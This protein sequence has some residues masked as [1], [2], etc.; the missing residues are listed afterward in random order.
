MPDEAPVTTARADGFGAGRAMDV[1]VGGG[2]IVVRRRSGR[3]QMADLSACL[4]HLPRSGEKRPVSDAL[5]CDSRLMGTR[6]SEF[7]VR[8]ARSRAGLASRRPPRGCVVAGPPQSGKTTVLQALRS[9]VDGPVITANGVGRTAGMVFSPFFPAAVVAFTAPA[10]LPLTQL[11]WSVATAIRERSAVALFIDDADQL[12]DQ[13]AA[14]VHSLV[15]HDAVPVYL[16]CT[17]DGGHPVPAALR[18]LWKDGHLPRFDLPPIDEREVHDYLLEVVGRPVTQRDVE[19]F[20]RWSGGEPG[21]LVDLVE[22]SLKAQQWQVISGTALLVERPVPPPEMLEEVE[23]LAADLSGEVLTMVEVFGAAIPAIGIRMLDWLPLAPVMELVGMDA[24]LEAERRGVIVADGDR[25]RLAVPFLADAVAR[26]TPQLRRAQIA[27][28]LAAAIKA[29]SGNPSGQVEGDQARVMTGLLTLSTTA[30]TPP[31]ERLASAR[32]ALRLGDAAAAGELASMRDGVAPT[33]EP[34]LAAVFTWASIHLNDLPG[35]Y[36]MLRTWSSDSSPAWRGLRMFLDEFTQRRELGGLGFLAR[37][38][39]ASGGLLGS[40]AER[41]RCDRLSGA[42]FGFLLAET[43]MLVGRYREA[44]ALLDLIGPAA[45]DDGLLIFHL[46]FVDERL[47]TAVTGAGRACDVVEKARRASAWRSDQVCASADFVCGLAHARAGRFD[48]ALS[49]LRNC[50]PFLVATRLQEAPARLIGR[51]DLMSTGSGPE[52]PDDEP[53]EIPVDPYALLTASEL[54]LDRAWALA[55]ADGVG[56]AVE[57]LLAFGE[58]ARESAPTLAVDQFELAAQFLPPGDS[59]AARRLVAGAEHI[60]AHV[61][62]AERV[63]A[64]VGYSAAL[65]AADGTRLKD[66]AEQY[67]RLCLLPVAA[68]VF[69]QAAAAY[70]AAGDVH[71]SL[72]SQSC[73]RRVIERIGHLASPAQRNVVR[74]SLTR[75]EEEIVALAAESL[76]N[77]QIADRLQLS[78][79]TVEGHLLRASGKFGVRDR[80]ALTALWQEQQRGSG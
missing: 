27:G 79:R 45:E 54:N 47:E 37:H 77:P 61:D 12:D 3:T 52:S 40:V 36:G 75:R 10:D 17:V 13:A 15:V 8:Q 51:V 50:A 62:S 80:R 32:S 21:V 69:A 9:D 11:R 70:R 18:S 38:D 66:A 14:I 57:R 78:V 59:D 19:A 44:R 5:P 43:A 58:G 4:Y 6:R 72:A 30:T 56:A 76:T 1:I 7:R 71:G 28:E 73:A 68:D 34:E 39:G 22:S 49:E 55:A 2:R 24:L 53:V 20:T 29:V 41:M 74:P 16:A 46:V 42:W 63:S 25:L 64:L 31:A 48:E 23:A 67:R 35:V 65:R 26:R 60:A 33:G